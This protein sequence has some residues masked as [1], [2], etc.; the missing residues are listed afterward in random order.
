MFSFSGH[1]DKNCRQPCALACAEAGVRTARGKT[2]GR[3]TQDSRTKVLPLAVRT[4]ASQFVLLPPMRFLLLLSLFIT[5]NLAAQDYR[6]ATLC[7]S[8]YAIF[9]NHLPDNYDR[10]SLMTALRAMPQPRYRLWIGYFEKDTNKIA[11][12]AAVD[13]PQSGLINRLKKIKS[14]GYF[15]EFYRDVP[16]IT[17]MRKKYCSIDQAY[18]S[19]A[20]LINGYAHRFWVFHRNGRI[21]SY[22]QHDKKGRKDGTWRTLDANGKVLSQTEY[23]EGVDVATIPKKKKK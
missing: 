3:K 5:V 6:T 1:K 2:A 10:D 19:K 12:V 4:L 16:A 22:G 11:F 17:S 18:R 8:G 13:R 9:P 23:A 15:F 20:Y 7:Q 21:A 14:D